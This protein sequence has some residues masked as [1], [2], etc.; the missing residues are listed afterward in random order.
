[1]TANK[2]LLAQIER[3]N[4]NICVNL[5]NIA[6]I[7]A[8][9]DQRLAGMEGKLERLPAER[10]PQLAQPQTGNCA[11]KEQE[12]NWA[13]WLDRRMDAL[14]R[15]QLELMQEVKAFVAAVDA[16]LTQLLTLLAQRPPLDPPP[17]PN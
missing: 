3:G 8:R 14:D 7:F 13:S 5:I 12:K 1:V 16:K 11:T 17:R 9:L 4:A 2:N 15:E 6:Q 10:P